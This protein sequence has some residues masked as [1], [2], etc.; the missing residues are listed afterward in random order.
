MVAITAVLLLPSSFSMLDTGDT[1]LWGTAS[2]VA[3]DSEGNE[4]L[5]QQVH[6]RI[7]NDGED[8]IL[9][10]TFATTA[11]GGDVDADD[12][13]M[14]AICAFTNGTNTNYVQV[15]ENITAAQV[16]R[17][18]SPQSDPRCQNSPLSLT[19]QGKA[20]LGPTTFSS[21]AA[22]GNT[23]SGNI[24]STRTIHGIAV[25]QA[26]ATGGTNGDWRRCLDGGGTVGQGILLSIIDTSDVVLTGTET[27][28][29]TYTF[30][31][32]SPND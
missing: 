24:T 15:N 22:A 6:N 8:F 1:N 12:D 26:N 2:L 3:Y 18:Q 14:G 25:C 27:V 21:G 10:Q 5:A 31:I 13:Q 16:D 17:H 4:I 32:T 7:V 29:I 11:V 23:G 30:D 20:I 9:V 19:T 28:D